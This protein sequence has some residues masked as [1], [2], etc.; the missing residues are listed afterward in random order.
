VGGEAIADA[1]QT[2]ASTTEVAQEMFTGKPEF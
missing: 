2:V 1:V